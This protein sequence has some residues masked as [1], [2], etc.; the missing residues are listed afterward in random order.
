MPAQTN[1]REPVKSFRRVCP[2]LFLLAQS[3]RFWTLL[4]DPEHPIVRP[5]ESIAD[6]QPRLQPALGIVDH[7]RC[8]LARF[9]LVAHLLDLR[10]LLF[11]RCDEICHRWFQLLSLFVLL[12]KLVEQHRVHGFVAYREHF[13]FG[14][15]SHQIRVSPFPPPPPQGQT[16]EYHWGQARAYS[17]RSPVS[18][19]IASL[20]LF[21]GLIWSVKRS[22][23]GATP[24]CPVLLTTTAAPVTAIP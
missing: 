1:A 22:E 3:V 13:P 17:G 5:L 21:I 20:A 4:S 15:P 10:R 24:S 11:H 8:W 14:I 19:R 2:A 7:P 18:V 6:T 9:K 16:A 23:E 12:E